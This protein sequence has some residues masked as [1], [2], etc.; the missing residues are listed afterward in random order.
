MATTHTNLERIRRTLTG[1]SDPQ[2]LAGT[3]ARAA[4]AYAA[5]S[6]APWTEG[7]EPRIPAHKVKTAEPSPGDAYRQTWGYD[8]ATST[9][10]S[11]C[12]AV[13]Y[14][15]R[16]PDDALTGDPCAVNGLSAALTGDRWLECGAIVT[17][18]VSGDAVPPAFDDFVEA[19]ESTAALL[20]PADT[21]GQGHT[22]EPNKRADT[23]AT[24][25]LAFATPPAA[26]Q[27]L[28]VLLRVADYTAVRGAWHEGGAMLD[29]DSV[30]VTFSRDVAPDTIPPSGVAFD[31]GCADADYLYSYLK[32]AGF[33][34]GRVFATYWI[35][36]TIGRRLDPGSYGP[37]G[38]DAAKNILA[39]FRVPPS[40]IGDDGNVMF[41]T[42]TQRNGS[43]VAYA[44]SIGI[45]TLSSTD[46][47]SALS[48]VFSGKTD[49]ATFTRL[50]FGSPIVTGI[51]C[52]VVVFGIGNPVPVAVNFTEI[53]TQT[54]IH[55]ITTMTPFLTAKSVFSDEFYCGKARQIY[56]HTDIQPIASSFTN[57]G[58]AIPG[59]TLA[60]FD[61]PSGTVSTVEF[62]QP[63]ETGPFAQIIVAMIPNGLIPLDNMSNPCK[64]TIIETDGVFPTLY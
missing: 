56:S 4:E 17:A 47:S 39:L 20:I 9:E 53:T 34:F 60:A 25:T 55:N 49:G 13:C 12:G 41:H 29:P 28:H 23:S 51:P 22:I 43:N 2:P 16:L 57:E 21:D 27:W 44:P 38:D 63:F 40:A 24:A 33:A 35:D 50:T 3:A 58:A 42:K 30:S 64:T 59:V 32:S 10:R 46:G 6:A 36:T 45:S 7:G 18:L 1:I 14:S 48:A 8:A 54:T 62:S 37:R 5:M 19:G 11:A 52:R 15:F 31:L 61:C 26:A